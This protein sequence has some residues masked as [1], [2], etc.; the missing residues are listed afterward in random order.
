MG[1]NTSIIQGCSHLRVANRF[2]VELVC[3]FSLASTALSR[4][5]CSVAGAPTPT[6][7]SRRASQPQPFL[8]PCPPSRKLRPSIQP[9]PPPSS[10]AMTCAGHLLSVQARRRR[11]A[12]HLHAGF[13][14][15][16]QTRLSR[17]SVHLQLRWLSGVRT[18][19][20]AG[21]LFVLLPLP[22]TDRSIIGRMTPSSRQG[23][24]PGKAWLRL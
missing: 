2:I 18:R 12:H 13:K 1:K 9:A 14:D 6:P 16:S 24:D 22:E 21:W 3:L 20:L 19:W 8:L 17:Y 7:T 23:P 4:P 15:K 10:A 11:K 5:R